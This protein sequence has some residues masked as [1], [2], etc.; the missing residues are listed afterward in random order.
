[1]KRLVPYP[2]IMRLFALISLLVLSLSAQ[3]QSDPLPSWNDG[4]AKQAIAAF[5]IE[6]ETVVLTGEPVVTELLAGRLSVE[7]ALADGLILIDGNESYKT[8]IRHVLIGMSMAN[9]ISRR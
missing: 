3:A 8:A 7:R 6:G 2:A 4:P 1:M 5:V 9:K